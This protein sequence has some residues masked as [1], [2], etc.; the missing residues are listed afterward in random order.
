MRSASCRS[1]GLC[2]SQN[3]RGGVKAL[4]VHGSTALREFERARFVEDG[5]VEVASEQC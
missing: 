4:V 2:H 5:E 3:D 1:D